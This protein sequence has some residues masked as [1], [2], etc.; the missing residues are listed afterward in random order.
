VTVSTSTA[1]G[2]TGGELPHS[3]SAS[4]LQECTRLP[5]V[6]RERDVEYQVCDVSGLTNFSK[7]AVSQ[8][9]VQVITS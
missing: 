4:D 9:E 7:Q 6:I 1:A 3:Q 8:V 2:S 5:V